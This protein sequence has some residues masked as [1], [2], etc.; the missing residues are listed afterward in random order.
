MRLYRLSILY[1]TYFL[2]NVAKCR[3]RTDECL[4][5]LV[6]IIYCVRDVVMFLS[7]FKLLTLSFYLGIRFTFVVRIKYASYDCSTK[8]DVL[9][10]N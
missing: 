4:T 7:N 3:V 2:P 10:I 9:K 1:S 5:T 8:N 6:F